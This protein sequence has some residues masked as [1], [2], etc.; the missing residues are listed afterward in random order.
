M[1]GTAEGCGAKSSGDSIIV[2][3]M[4]RDTYFLVVEGFELSG[5]WGKKTPR[6]G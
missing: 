6:E 2:G 4:I 3:K 5:G 1:D